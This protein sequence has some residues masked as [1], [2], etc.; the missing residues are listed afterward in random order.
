MHYLFLLYIWQVF[1]CVMIRHRDN[2]LTELVYQ[3]NGSVMDTMTALRVKTNL[4]VVSIF[5]NILQVENCADTLRS[6][7]RCFM[8]LKLINYLF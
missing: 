2:V 3:K 8:V 4:I 5:R 7:L 6:V 1:V